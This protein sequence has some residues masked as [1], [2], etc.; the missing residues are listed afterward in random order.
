MANELRHWPVWMLGG[1]LL[2]PLAQ[3]FPFGKKTPYES[4]CAVLTTGGDTSVY[5]GYGSGPDAESAKVN[6]LKD[7]AERINV[8]VEGNVTTVT[9]LKNRKADQ[10]FSS[11]ATLKSKLKVQNA[12][13]ICVD[14][15]DPARIW[16]V[17]FEL[18]T[19]PPVLLLGQRLGAVLRG[20]PVNFT[21]NSQLVRSGLAGELAAAVSAGRAAGGQAVS[22]PLQLRRQH[23][24][25]YLIAGAEQVQLRDEDLFKALELPHSPDVLLTLLNDG[26]KERPVSQLQQG[27]HFSLRV[28]AGR[29]GYLSLF[30]IYADGRVS[31]LAV[32]QPLK[33]STPA[34]LPEAGQTFEA[35]LL[36]PN[37]SARDIYIAA[38]S[39]KPLDRATMH[40]LRADQGMVKGDDS[41]QLEEVL[42][43]LDKSGAATASIIITTLPN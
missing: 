16:H 19:R 13:Q 26:G 4:P 20:A 17:V 33:D 36:T 37:E 3:A 24:G 2:S 12:R 5:R 22:L 7:I 34:V 38:V 41:Y 25:W 15:K 30:N 10:S 14:N 18:D 32:N 27:D 8:E 35:G 11:T 29:Q 6:A 31:L 39:E 9:T 28:D 42:A 21:G 1:L 23:G 43:L 40:Q